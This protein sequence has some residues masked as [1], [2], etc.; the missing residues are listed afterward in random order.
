M[1]LHPE[2]Y[3]KKFKN[4]KFITLRRDLNL[5]Q[6]T[7]AGVGIILGAGIYALIGIAAGEAGNAVWLSFFF[8]AL[9]AA[10]TGLSYAEL[11][12][13]FPK[14]AGEYLY[15]EHAFGK[16]IAFVVG[17]LVII[18]GVVSAAAVALGFAGYFS[19][20]FNTNLLLIIAIAV[21]VIFSLVNFYGIK[22]SSF[23]NIIFTLIEVIGLLLIIALATRYFGNINYFEMPN[24]LKGVF[25]AA[26]LIFFAYIG[27]DSIVKLSEETKKANKIIP[28]ALVLSIIIT[29]ILYITVAAAA[30][31]ILNW[32]TLGASKA[33]LADVAKEVL[34]IK[35]FILLAVIAL[36]STGNTVLMELI[37]TSRMLYGM[38]K[39]GFSNLLARIH[40]IRRTPYI[41]IFITMIMAILFVL[42]KDIGL[43][44]EITNF[45]IFSVFILINSS[46]IKLRYKESNRKRIFYMPLN[47]GKFPVLS[48]LGILTCIFLMFNLQFIVI[49]SGFGMIIFGF[50]LYSLIEKLKVS[51]INVRKQ[52]IF[53]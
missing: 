5:F 46:L 3:H 12:S 40:P 26:A 8:A 15:T 21:I 11:S 34:G 9:V 43:V 42:I 35:A 39:E 31:S 25:S 13:M 44:A 14:D 2:H 1:K 19:S 28:K 29:T 45:A 27:F 41:A 49:L 50:I 16:R 48:L 37:V 36:F 24:G 6:A 7:A 32:Q 30:V 38:G 51:K 47:I 4:K 18:A 20:L 33:P 17:F 22:Q 53:K 52:K 23:L 10:F